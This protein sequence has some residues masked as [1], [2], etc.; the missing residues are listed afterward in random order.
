MSS[1]PKTSSSARLVAH[2]FSS[3]PVRPPAA[4]VK[5]KLRTTFQS[6][7]RRNRQKRIDVPIAWGI[8]TM[9]TASF[10][11]VVRAIAGVSKLPMPKPATDA[12]APPKTAAKNTTSSNTERDPRHGRVPR[13]FSDQCPDRERSDWY[14]RCARERDECVADDRDP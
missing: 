3:A 14:P 7:S 6:T 1:E 5:P 13:G 10:A 9:A 8:D 11:P 4:L 12:T 2:V